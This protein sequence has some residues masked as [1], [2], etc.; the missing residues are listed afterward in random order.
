MSS[1]RVAS[2]TQFLRG[3]GALMIV[4]AVAYVGLF[5]VLGAIFNYPAVLREP[6]GEV[7]RRF[8][9]GGPT[10]VQVWYALASTALLFLPVA[11]VLPRALDHNRLTGLTA[12]GFTGTVG[13]LAALA[14]TLGLARWVFLVPFLAATY[15]DPASSSAMR[16]SVLVTF[17][18]FHRYLGAGVGEHLGYLLTGSWT[19][20]VAGR[21][22][23]APGFGRFFA[24]PG[25]L[26]GIGILIGLF[27]LAGLEVAS[28]INA[29]GYIL[30]SVWLAA[31]GIRLLIGLPAEGPVTSALTPS[32]SP[33]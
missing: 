7:L 15:V 14:Q 28:V 5:S 19:L 4:E 30:W 11:I 22:A 6:G 3:M 27:E 18:A 25:F 2:E 13:I 32:A 12:V 33:A 9:E 29:A 8:A 10:L 21:M 24:I 1:P 23:S 17:E 26:A 20:L 16:D 31:A